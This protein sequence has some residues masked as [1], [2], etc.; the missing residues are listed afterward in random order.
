MIHFLLACVQPES[1]NMMAHAAFE[2]GCRLNTCFAIHETAA[3]VPADGFVVS[4]GG[5]GGRLNILMW[6][7]S[8]ADGP[9]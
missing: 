4:Y 6:L 2:L 3:T 1:F 5:A 9:P 8:G 7:Y